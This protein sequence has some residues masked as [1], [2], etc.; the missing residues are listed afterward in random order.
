MVGRFKRLKKKIV[1]K[2]EASRSRFH[3]IDGPLQG[4]IFY[5]YTF[6][7]KRTDVSIG[8]QMI[9]KAANDEYDIAL[10]F[11]GDTDFEPAIDAVQ[12]TFGKQIIVAVPNKRI[13]GSIKR[14]VPVGNCVSI[15]EQDIAA[16]QLP[17]P[18]LLDN[19]TQLTCPQ[20]WK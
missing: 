18:L 10:L 7:E 3:T 14:I 11:S 16:S 1:V 5:G 8:C 19:D 13:S 20:S 9:A 4:S 12:N 15:R 6:E 2:N 17:D